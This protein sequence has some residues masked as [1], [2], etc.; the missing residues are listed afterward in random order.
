M[1]RYLTSLDQRLE[2]GVGNKLE[3]CRHRLKVCANSQALQRPY[4]ITG[5]RQQT[6]DMLT[7]AL[8][9]V[10]KLML[11]DKG[12]ILATL[13]GKLD[14]L[15]PLSTLARGYS[16]CTTPDGQ[17][18]TDMEDI[19]KGDLVSVKLNKGSLHC[20]VEGKEEA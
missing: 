5:N 6:V 3:R 18:I 9:R 14:I 15:S 13:A 7:A 16:I 11:A 19:I 17:I 12:T 2:K 4:L 8:H 10:G 1:H 20:T